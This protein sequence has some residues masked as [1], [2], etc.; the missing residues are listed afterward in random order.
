M[1][2]TLIAALIICHFFSDWILQPRWMAENKSKSVGLCLWHGM[3]TGMALAFTLAFFT[4]QVYLLIFLSFSY[5]LVHATQDML[6]WRAY[7]RYKT[8]DVE[9][10]KDY[11][12]YT[13]I[14]ID[15]T[16]HLLV[17]FGFAIIIL[18]G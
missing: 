13:T 17:I 4:H 14:A 7:P 3:I 9:F 15:Q 18:M 2:F 5:A 16:L 12:F 10:Y 1:S 6:V 11:W 8:K